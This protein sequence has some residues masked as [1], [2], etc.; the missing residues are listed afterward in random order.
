[1][2]DGIKDMT[3]RALVTLV[4]ISAFLATVIHA[5]P[6]A[7]KFDVAAIK[8][9]N[10][11]A[12]GQFV[13]MPSPGRISVTNMTLQQLIRFAYSEGI[14]ANLEIAGGPNWL[15]KDRFDVEAKAEGTPTQPE[16][17][18]MI[19]GLLAD[20]F[21]LKSHTETKEVNVYAMMLARSDGNLGPKVQPWDGKCNGREAPPARPNG[22][23]V[24]RCGAFFRPPGMALEGASMVVL[25]DMLSTPIANL[26]RPV[27][28]RTGLSGEYTLQLEFPFRMPNAPAAAGADESL[29][30]SLFTALQEQLGLKLQSARGNVDILVVDQAQRPTE[31]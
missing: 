22:T 23:H 19:Q 2:M 16:L 4:L 6:A 26:G 9:S 29:A 14:G 3:R 18:L 31:N 20:R 11:D 21:A 13:R 12:T 10:P 17:R 8:P 25:A 28:D 7:P 5:Q 27:V 15:D 30:P 1:M 24:L